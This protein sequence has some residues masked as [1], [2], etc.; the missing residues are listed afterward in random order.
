MSF[1][2]IILAGCF[3]SLFLGL[4]SLF[5]EAGYRVDLRRR[6]SRPLSGGRRSSDPAASHA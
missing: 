2:T 3:F 1:T 4:V 6:V 5:F